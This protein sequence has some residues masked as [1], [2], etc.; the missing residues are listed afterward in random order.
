MSNGINPNINHKKRKQ[1]TAVEYLNGLASGD[2]YLLSE[3]LT[4]IESNA[5]DKSV[6][7]DKILSQITDKDSIGTL[8]IGITGSP[9]AGKSTLIE[10]LGLHLIGEGNRVAVLAIDPSSSKTDG[11]ILGDKTR[12]PLLSA[13]NN[14]YVRPTA[15][16]T[17]LG[18][19]SKSTR[20][21]I[22]VCEKAGYN[23]ILIESVGVGQSEVELSNLVDA[24]VLLLLPGGGD[25]IQGIKR[26]VVELADIIAINKADGER[27]ALAKN[28]KKDYGGVIKLFPHDLNG[29][30]PKV[31]ITSA[32]ENIGIEELWKTISEY[33]SLSKE[34]GYFKTRR[35]EQGELYIKGQIHHFI[36]QMVTKDLL[37]E[38]KENYENQED[39]TSLFRRTRTILDGIA[40]KMKS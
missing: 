39:S 20:E 10:Q 4:I 3:V 40:K 16:A 34:E 32:L 35:K 8:R 38:E 19:V 6:L 18:G 36:E 7:A 13:E 30:S 29:W 33:I 27:I 37:P 25:D 24:Y 5:P 31:L 26:G 14:A 17:H 11:S 1:K 21:A 15:S 12:M 9:G 23:I 28:S 22:A 2:R